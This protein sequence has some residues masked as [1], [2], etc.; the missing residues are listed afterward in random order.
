MEE[1]QVGH[2][3]KPTVVPDVRCST[4][5]APVCSGKGHRLSVDVENNESSIVK[6]TDTVLITKKSIL[7]AP[8]KIPPTL[9]QGLGHS[10][11]KLQTTHKTT[12]RKPT[13]LYPKSNY[14]QMGWNYGTHDNQNLQPPIFNQWGPFPS[15]PYMGQSYGMHNLNGPMRHWGPNV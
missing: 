7:G 3:E 12:H 1:K 14:H 4:D 15:F 10:R 2:F 11:S 6:Q 13:G 9:K 5:K 8:K